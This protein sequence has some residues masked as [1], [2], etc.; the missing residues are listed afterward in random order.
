[1]FQSI[2]RDKKGNLALLALTLIVAFTY[3]ELQYGEFIYL[4]T[5]QYVSLNMRVLSGLSWK[6]IVWGATTFDVAN[7]H[8]LTW[9]SYMLDTT[10]F[11]ANPRG[12]FIHN[13]L[14]HIANTL[15]L[16]L[17]L[18]R[19]TD[20][21]WESLLVALLFAVHPLNVENVAWIGQRKSLLATFWGFMAI[22][23]Y[24]TYAAQ[25]R[26][27]TYLLSLFCFF[28]SLL[29]KPMLVT[30]PF[31]FF[32][33]DLWPLNRFPLLLGQWRNFLRQGFRL[34]PEKIPFLTLAAF[35]SY[36]TVR[37][38]GGGGAILSTERLSLFNR[39]G[40][41]IFSY[42]RYL[43][44]LFLPGELAVYYPLNYTA[45]PWPQVIA[46][47]I[48]LCAIS[49]VAVLLIKKKPF[50]FTGWFWY[51]GTMVPVIG[52]VQVG[53]MSHA[54][55]YLYFP[56]IGFFIAVIWSCRELMT[57]LVL[58]KV[59]VAL[60]LILAGFFIFETRALV[61]IWE[62]STTLFQHTLRITKGNMII[63]NNLGIVYLHQGQLDEAE[64]VLLNAI[65][66]KDTYKMPFR[67]LAQVYTRK[68]EF[69]K[70][71]FYLK[72][73]L[74]IEPAFF[75]AQL[76]LADNYARMDRKEQAK[77]AL[78]RAIE[79]RPGSAST[80]LWLSNLL[81]FEETD[82]AI[83]V[84]EAAIEKIPDDAEL[85]RALA[86]FLNEKGERNKAVTSFRRSLALNPTLP[87]TNYRLGRLFADMNNIFGARK[88][89]EQE[90]KVN[91]D[92]G[93]PYHTL[94]MT[95][96]IEGKYRE[97]IGYLIQAVEKDP[98]L[99]QSHLELGRFFL[100]NRD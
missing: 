55:R 68:G 3:W 12:H 20:R 99:V 28:L 4:D 34:V 51:V 58:R 79:I 81:G 40:N 6:N 62:T 54:D 64:Q 60:V 46:L 87:D 70:A 29:A 56:A 53:G 10:L 52:L 43:K 94:G 82:K 48:A 31:L 24:A 45:H 37:A 49:L 8:P 80:H 75:G 93:E 63:M 67:N 17:L 72:E 36:M 96:I 44:D 78:R 76:D 95:Y 22:W 32:L 15:L 26:W 91:P 9:W 65:K 21:F 97:G 85:H 59:A 38:Q 33:L 90:I 2:F 89:F 18:R 98:H 27:Q 66:A 83:S 92:F 73:V 11:Q 42:M 19:L 30:L 88:S 7:W 86:I 5:T 50:I 100:S 14:L 25:R 16:F 47:L 61:R 1:L 84:L 41:V 23:T 74:Q 57:R 35:D 13:I 39:L 69:D 71:V 77:D